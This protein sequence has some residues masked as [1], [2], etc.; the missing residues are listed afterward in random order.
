MK[1]TKITQNDLILLMSHAREYLLAMPNVAYLDGMGRPLTDGE[2]LA[3]AYTGAAWIV[4]GSYGVDT[5][6]LVVAYDDSEH[7][8]I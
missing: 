1:K 4:A 2:R 7:D 6:N 5:S 8:P 3:L